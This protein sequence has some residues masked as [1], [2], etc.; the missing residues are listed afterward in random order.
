MC[1]IYVICVLYIYIISISVTW[2]CF[3]FPLLFQRVGLAVI[4]DLPRPRAKKGIVTFFTNLSE[5]YQNFQ[6]WFAVKRKA[7][8]Y[9]R[10]LFFLVPGLILLIH[11]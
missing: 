11:G 10:D 8:G 3:A 1:I 7:M 4:S 5:R 6:K 2:C 9:S